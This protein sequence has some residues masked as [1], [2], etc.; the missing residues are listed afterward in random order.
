MQPQRPDPSRSSLSQ[1]R[2]G[3]THRGPEK[4]CFR[5]W[6]ASSSCAVATDFDQDGDLDVFIG[7]RVIPGRYPETPSSRLLRNDQGQWVDDVTEEV[8]PGLRKVGMVTSALWSDLNGDGLIDLMGGSGGGA[9]Q[10]FKQQGPETGS[11]HEGKRLVGP[12]RMVECPPGSGCRP[13]RRHRHPC[14]ECGA[15]HQVW[16]THDHLAHLSFLRSHGCHSST[17]ADWKRAAGGGHPSPHTRPGDRRIPSCHGSTRNFLPI[18]IMH[19][20]DL[21]DIYPQEMLNQAQ[22]LEANQLAS[23]ACGSIEAMAPLT[24]RLSPGWPKPHRDSVSR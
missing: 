14:D 6:R 12:P 24:G 2:S 20:P 21:Q 18:G 5:P 10:L 3:P 8:A 17:K 11:S 16:R 22:R 15:E 1:Q 23:E 7:G 19:G 13:G 9:I 4:A